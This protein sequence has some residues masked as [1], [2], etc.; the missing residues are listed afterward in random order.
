M[1]EIMSLYS[2]KLDFRLCGVKTARCTLKRRKNK[3]RICNQKLCALLTRDPEIL[4]FWFLAG[5]WLCAL[6]F[7]FTCGAYTGRLLTALTHFLIPS[8]GLFSPSQ[9][10]YYMWLAKGQK[11]L[12]TFNKS[13][14]CNWGLLKTLEWRSTIILLLKSNSVTYLLVMVTLFR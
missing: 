11:I 8:T 2:Q 7:E 9:W 6:F 4:F 3:P 12:L 10:D 13:S 1:R 5:A 14:L